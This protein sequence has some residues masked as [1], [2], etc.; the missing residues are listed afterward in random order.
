MHNFHEGR[1][2]V[3]M[4]RVEDGKKRLAKAVEIDWVMQERIVECDELEAIW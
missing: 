3:R 2:L 1:L 4:G